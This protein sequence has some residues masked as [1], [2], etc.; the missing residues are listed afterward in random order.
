MARQDDEKRKKEL[1]EKIRKKEEEAKAVAAAAAEKEAVPVPVQEVEID[2]TAE[3]SGPR[4]VEKL[5]S[6]GP[7][8]PDHKVAHGLEEAEAPGTVSSAAEGP[9]EPPV[10]PR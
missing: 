5:E 1:E 2:A 9:K 3:L 8:G 10:L 6:P 4:E 7:Q